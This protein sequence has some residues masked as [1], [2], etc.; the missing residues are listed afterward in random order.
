[1]QSVCAKFGRDRNLKGMVDKIQHIEHIPRRCK[2]SS[3]KA[4]LK[5]PHAE[6]G[7]YGSLKMRLYRKST[8]KCVLLLGKAN[9]D[10]YRKSF[11]EVLSVPF[12]GPKISQLNPHFWIEP[13]KKQDFE[14]Q[15][16]ADSAID[17]ASQSIATQKYIYRN[18]LA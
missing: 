4:Y 8:A 6:L 5:R 12:R 1:M 17:A 7:E 2:T 14:A 18:V 13:N 16:K 11:L 15:N 3:K 9:S 10:W